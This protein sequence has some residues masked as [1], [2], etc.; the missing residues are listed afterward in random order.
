VTTVLTAEGPNAEQIRYWNEAAG[1]RWVANQE[2]LD[3]QIAPL[4][5]AAMDRAAIR[6]G[7]HVLDV[8]CGCGATTIELARRVAP[9]GSVLG[10]DLSRVMLEAARE[11]AEGAGVAGVRFE[12]A[13]AQTYA[14]ESGGLDLVFSRFGVMF[15][16][17]PEAAFANLARALRSGGR[18]AFVCWQALPLNPWMAVPVMAA[19]QHVQLPP[20][21]APGAPGPFSFADEGRVR[22]ILAAAGFAD[23]ALAPH[24]AKL[25]VGGGRNLDATVEIMLQLGPAAAAL[26]DASEEV[27]GR[28][29]PA[30]REA[31][32]PYWTESG[33]SMDSA[34]W[35]VTARRP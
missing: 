24:H 13:D 27:R 34:C 33:V 16:A 35:L 10:L 11:A 5:L 7:E 14:P 2:V 23:I 26:R 8:G 29:R 21:P 6:P 4:G 25:A 22:E 19:M 28:V 1:P 9:G 30:V 3:R 20:P 18:L 31:L 12:N 17:E 15:F 32:A